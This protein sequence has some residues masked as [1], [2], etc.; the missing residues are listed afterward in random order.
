MCRTIR[1]SDAFTS[2]PVFAMRPNY[3][4]QLFSQSG[5]Q[6]RRQLSLL[7]RRI[8]RAL[9]LKVLVVKRQRRM[10]NARQKAIIKE[11]L[12]WEMDLLHAFDTMLHNYVV[13]RLFSVA[14][15]EKDLKAARRNQTQSTMRRQGGR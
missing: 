7:K 6:V 15:L 3:A 14:R 10:H 4:S 13:H 9:R 12:V 8:E 11:P 5:S 2:T 1:F